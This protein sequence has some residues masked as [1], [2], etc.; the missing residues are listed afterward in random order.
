MEWMWGEKIEMQEGGI[1]SLVTS[2]FFNTW[3][4]TS[5]GIW[6]LYPH[7]PTTPHPHLSFV[8]SPTSK[9]LKLALSLFFF[10]LFSSFFIKREVS[11]SRGKSGSFKVW[12]HNG[13]CIDSRLQSKWWVAVFWKHVKV[14]VEVVVPFVISLF[15]KKKKSPWVFSFGPFLIIRIHSFIANPLPTYSLYLF[16]FSL[17]CINS[18]YLQNVYIK[19][20]LVLYLFI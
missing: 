3:G 8:G 18:G 19:S 4:L 1:S 15:F 12:T 13:G 7:S 5:S 10:F 11:S 14:D 6:T 9:N 2:F 17:F 16:T 20:P